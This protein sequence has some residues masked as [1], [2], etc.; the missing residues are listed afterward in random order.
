MNSTIPINGENHT[1]SKYYV[2]TEFL[3]K[4]QIKA[5]HNVKN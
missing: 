3:D 2:K 5:T 1:F 4:K